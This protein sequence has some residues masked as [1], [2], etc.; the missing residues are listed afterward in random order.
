MPV[1]PMKTNPRPR[2]PCLSSAHLTPR[3]SH[4]EACRMAGRGRRPAAGFAP[5]TR[6]AAG[7]RPGVRSLCEEL[8]GRLGISKAGR[9]TGDEAMSRID[10]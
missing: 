8:A 10:P 4:P 1:S 6:E 9:G 3:G 5:R 2:D 7:Q